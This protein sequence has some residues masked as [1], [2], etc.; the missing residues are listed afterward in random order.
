MDNA[1]LVECRKVKVLS[2][3]MENP[4]NVHR[5]RL[6]EGADDSASE[7]IQ[8]IQILQAWK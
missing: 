3:E 2:E 5:W 7:M 1:L 6:L 8:K 4:R